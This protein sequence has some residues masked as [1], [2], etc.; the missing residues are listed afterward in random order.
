MPIKPMVNG[1]LLLL[2]VFKV[3]I[4]KLNLLN[5]HQINNVKIIVG[6][7]SENLLYFLFILIYLLTI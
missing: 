5:V 2:N 3:R 6:E 7:D 4:V 1:V